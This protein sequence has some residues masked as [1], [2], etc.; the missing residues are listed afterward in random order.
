MDKNSLTAREVVAAWADFDN[1]IHRNYLVSLKDAT[2]VSERASDMYDF[3]KACGLIQ[4]DRICKIVYDKS[5]NTLVKLNS[6]YSSLVTARQSV[7]VL[8]RKNGAETALYIGTRGQDEDEAIASRQVL[9]GSIAG[10]FPGLRLSSL[11]NKEVCAISREISKKRCVSIVTGVPDL[12][13]DANDETFSQ[14][15]EKIIEAQGGQ[16]F[17][18]LILAKP[19]S[20][21]NLRT[22]E[23]GYQQLASQ[24]SLLNVSQLTLSSQDSHTVGRSV[25]MSVSKTFSESMSLASSESTS[26]GKTKTPAQALASIGAAVG[27]GIGTAVGPTGTATGAVLGGAIG[28]AVGSFA[29]A[30]FG[31]T[32]HTVTKALTET[33][34]KSHGRTDSQ[35]STDSESSTTSSGTSTT[36]AIQDRQVADAIAIVDEQLKRIRK[37]KSYGAWKFAAYFIADVMDCAQT[38][39][40]VYAGVLRGQNTGVERCCVSNWSSSDRCYKGIIADL[41]CFDHPKFAVSRFDA[42]GGV[43]VTP[44]SIITTQ[45]LSVG[46]SL[47]RK[48]LPGVP[49]F[50]SVE[51][52]RSVTTYDLRKGVQ[53]PIGKVSR[54]GEVEDGVVSLDRDS[55]ASHLFVTGSTGAGKSTFI[56]ALL[57]KLFNENIPFLVVEPAKGEYKN[58]LGSLEGVSVFGTN[59]Y[60]FS[61]ILRLNPFSFPEKVHVMEHIDRLIE[62][63]NAAWPMYAAMP[64]I[65]KEAVEGAYRRCGWDLSRSVCKGPRV[66]PDFS[67]LLVELPE[68]ISASAYDTEVKSN[69]TGALVTRIKSLTNGYYRAIFQKDEIAP[70]C[71]FDSSAIVDISRVGSSETK[72]LLMGVLFLKLQEH[73][74]SSATTAN[75]ALKHVTV[76]EEAHNLLR[77]TGTSQGMETANLLGKS[78]EMMTNAIAEMRTYG[79]GF[80]IADQAPGLLDPAVIRNTNTKVVLSLPDAEDRALVG[81]AQNLNEDQVNELARLKTGCASVYQ[82][83]WQEAVLCQIDDEYARHPSKL[84]VPVVDER[85]FIDSRTVATVA[86]V[87]V[88]L[89]RLAETIDFK[90]A[91]EVLTKSEEALVRLYFSNS[92]VFESG[93]QTEADLL[94]EFYSAFVRRA[95]DD[96]P[97]V[98][99]RKKWTRMLIDRMFAN[100]AL[101]SLSND[102]RDVVLVCLFKSLARYDA[103][104]EQREVWRSEVKNISCWRTW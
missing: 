36:Y 43:V 97:K 50:N 26:D 28:T 25:G 38:G 33:N 98:S 59:P 63:L 72:S 14:G 45:E 2:G 86:Y 49:V 83:N 79:E 70:E 42:D 88:L 1:L 67:D 55:L 56:Y 20:D 78:V 74:M 93:S 95:K 90:R 66:F 5:E 58:A 71:L 54:L 62:I 46:M 32:T 41:R 27:A 52:G 99:D 12:K 69:Y 76:L 6:V 39:A 94:D 15:I 81:K 37:A 96:V 53:I 92:K 11:S 91:E 29:G 57:R 47:P 40:N 23:I 103:H 60:A 77:R 22:L 100:D 30:F 9:E 101:A 3:D 82:N 44:T 16:D 75:S 34:T 4:V 21:D 102:L 61:K 85:N 68:V 7:F 19:V 13:E 17:T 89:G 8:I 18:A 104:P 73:R 65:L 10:N 80:I 31:S 87:R 35:S 64:A 84:Y 51:F 48:A 24:L